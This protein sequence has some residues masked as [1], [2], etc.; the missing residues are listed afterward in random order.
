MQWIIVIFWFNSIRSQTLNINWKAAF[1]FLR[2][3]WFMV[4]DD[5]L[6]KR[7]FSTF[8]KRCKTRKT[9][10]CRFEYTM[11]LQ[12]WLLRRNFQQIWLSIFP[13]VILNR[14]SWMRIVKWI[15]AGRRVWQFGDRRDKILSKLK[16]NLL[17]RRYVGRVH[18][19]KY[20]IV[21]NTICS[22]L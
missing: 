6:T 22:F 11:F 13:K 15:S 5:S 4:W 20:I 17:D 21:L 10:T 1:Y 8:F 19:R 12:A 16:R 9:C 14:Y 2:I 3:N 7:S 18:F